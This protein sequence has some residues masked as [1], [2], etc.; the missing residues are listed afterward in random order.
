MLNT[1]IRMTA[2]KMIVCFGSNFSEEYKMAFW[3]DGE[4]MR[5]S[6]VNLKR[7]K[8]TVISSENKPHLVIC[9]FLGRNL[10]ADKDLKVIGAL[11]QKYM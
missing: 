4:I 5:S 1:L 3:G 11:M 9:P 7:S 10:T 8:I 6:S 2:P